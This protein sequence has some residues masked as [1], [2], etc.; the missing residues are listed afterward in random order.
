MRLS[1]TMPIHYDDFSDSTSL[2][3]HRLNDDVSRLS[4]EEQTAGFSPIKNVLAIVAI[5]QQDDEQNQ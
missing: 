2:D 3:V 5:Q 4:K 1:V